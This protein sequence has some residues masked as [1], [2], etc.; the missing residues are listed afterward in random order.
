MHNVDFKNYEGSTFL[1]SHSPTSKWKDILGIGTSTGNSINRNYCHFIICFTY[2]N[3]HTSNVHHQKSGIS[4]SS[5]I[6]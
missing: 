3:I 4:M 6:G 5:L 1:I 2:S